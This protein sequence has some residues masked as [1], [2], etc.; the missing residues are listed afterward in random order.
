VC[1]CCC[2][3]YVTNLSTLHYIALHAPVKTRVGTPF[4]ANERLIGGTYTA[5]ILASV[6]GCLIYC[7]AIAAT[8][9]DP[10]FLW[11]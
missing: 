8:L 2:L 3:P 11:W 7:C 6:L 1:C 9:Q 10:L 5:S 4:R